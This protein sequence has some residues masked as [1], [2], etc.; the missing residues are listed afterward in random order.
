MKLSEIAAEYAGKINDKKLSEMF[1]K[2]FMSTYETTVQQDD[3]GSCFVITGD[4]PAMWLRDSSAQV[5]HY[6]SFAKKSEEAY[7]VI[8]GLIRRQIV[9]I[10]ADP[11]ANAFNREANGLGHQKDKTEQ[12]PYVWERKYEIDSLCYPVRLAYRFWKQAETTSH[13]TEDM[14]K[15]FYKIIDV[16]TVEQKHENSPYYFIR[17]FCSKKETL[18]RK[19]KGAPVGY[20]GMTWS[21]FRPS[22]DSCKY[23]YLVP[24]NMFA[25]VVLGY[26]SEIAREIYKDSE[27]ESKAAKLRQ[28]I[29]GGIEKYA[30]VNDGSGEF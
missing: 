10:L 20:T 5:N 7:D 17:R 9:C 12:S 27:L 19:G 30:V 1:V 6:V 18:S 14:R 4:I 25:A 15:A 24:A 21:G 23:G 13:F 2:C 22:D 16:W 8:S 29:I 11:Y 28:E 26:I 3:D